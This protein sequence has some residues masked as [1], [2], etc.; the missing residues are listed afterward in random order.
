VVLLTTV[1]TTE[2]AA[3]GFT[4]LS[5]LIKDQ[6]GTQ[7]DLLGRSFPLGTIMDPATTRPV[8]AGAVDPA[9]GLTATAN[10]YLRDPFPNNL[11]FTRIGTSRF[12]PVNTEVSLHRSSSRLSRLS[13][14]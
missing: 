14:V 6:S 13:A 2:E 8:T 10:G 4:D 12:Q 3:S 9:T 11:G 7:T 1:P 5:Q